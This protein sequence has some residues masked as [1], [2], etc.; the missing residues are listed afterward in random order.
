M[1]AGSIHMYE[2]SRYNVRVTGRG[3]RTL[4]LA[5]GYGCDQNMWRFITPAF[6]RE[7]RII[8]FDYIGHGGSDASA[9]DHDRYATLEGYADDVVRIC[10]AL[11]VRNAVF[12]GHSV[13]AMIGILASRKAPECFESLILIGPSPCYI[14]DA[15]YHGGFT[16]A[17]IDSLLEQLDS[18]HLGWSASMAPAIMGNPER[19]ELGTELANSF[20]RTDPEVARHFARVTFLS[21]NRS[22]LP[23]VANRCLVLQCAEDIIAPVTV[24]KYVQ[25]KIPG[26]ELV[27]LRATGHCPHLSAPRETIEAIKSFLAAGRP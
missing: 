14:N 3:P 27:L 7:F 10:K 16:R 25:Q 4:V 21:D 15:E 17:D 2:L 24:G 19:P 1:L 11:A 13:S 9:F 6:E 8:T 20:C 18:N 22:D 23:N 5:H 26:S 12:I